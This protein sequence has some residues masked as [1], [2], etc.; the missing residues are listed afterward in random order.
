MHSNPLFNGASFIS[1]TILGKDWV[2]HFGQSDGTD[3]GREGGATS[4][5][6]CEVRL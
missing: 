4:V 3:S 5:Q 2:C 1:V 6:H